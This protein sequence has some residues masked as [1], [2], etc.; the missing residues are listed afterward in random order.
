M[1]VDDYQFDAKW[2]LVLRYLTSHGE[3]PPADKDVDGQ[4]TY[5]GRVQQLMDDAEFMAAL[6]AAAANREM[7]GADVE[8]E[9]IYDA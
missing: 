7:G 6:Q 5:M 9:D 4:I 1:V 8:S 3:E 2:D